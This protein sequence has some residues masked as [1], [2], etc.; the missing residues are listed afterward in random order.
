MP[1]DTQE[2]SSDNLLQ[3]G[4]IAPKNTPSEQR[5]LSEYF[6][7]TIRVSPYRRGGY[8]DLVWF[9]NITKEVLFIK[10]NTDAKVFVVGMEPK[11]KYPPNYD[12][13]L[14]SH[15][16]VYSGYLNFAGP[17]FKGKFLPYTFPVH[18]R[19]FMADAFQKS[20]HAQRNYDFCTFATHD[21]NIRKDLAAKASRYRC[22]SGGPL[23]GFRVEDKLSIQRQCKYELITENDLNDYY[24]SEKLGA[25]L[26][27]G[28]VPVYLGG[29]RASELFPKNLWIDM[30]DFSGS[31]QLPDVDAIIDYC[32]K[33]GVYEKYRHEIEKALPLLL[34]RCSIEGCL[35]E[36]VE[37]YAKELISSGWRSTH[38]SILWRLN[39][40][41][42]RLA[43]VFG[44]S[45]T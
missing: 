3:V 42:L 33:P 7:P 35:I 12:A 29:G 10:K 18:P 14:L 8:Y 13:F 31:G 45:I 30:R 19:T 41:R 24:V 23:F 39:G 40:I 16:D 44:A 36:P 37:K 1:E 43:D 28:C 4:M 20:M 32:M 17:D 15:A 9:L 22:L 5:W 21:P 34:D 38:R 27:G 6:D 26:L 25:A 11:F 2:R